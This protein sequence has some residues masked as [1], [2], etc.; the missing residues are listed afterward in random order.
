MKQILCFGLIVFMFAAFIFSAVGAE[1]FDS[2]NFYNADSDTAYSA[3]FY[4]KHTEIFRSGELMVDI[5]LK[6]ILSCSA[7][8]DF[9]YLF[10]ADNLNCQLCIYRYNPA[11]NI[12]DSYAV[13]VNPIYDK[14]CFA[15]D[16]SGNIYFA[17]AYNTNFLYVQNINDY[18]VNNYKIDSRIC[19][20]INAGNDKILII[21]DVSVYAYEN[22]VCEKRLS[23]SLTY[24]VRYESKD[25]IS[26]ADG[27]KYNLTGFDYID[28][29]TLHHT[30][31]Q[32]TQSV[33]TTPV[34]PEDESEESEIRYEEISE[35]TY[36]VP[37][38]TT[39][40]KIKRAFASSVVTEIAKA[41]GGVIESGKVGTGT[42][43]YFE[44]GEVITLVI[45]SDVT[46][47]GN[48]NSRDTKAILDTLV[49]KQSLREPFFTAADLDY[50]GEITTKDALIISGMY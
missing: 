31:P 44:N 42:R 29:T 49:G 43:V 34:K 50:N 37:F 4:H 26:D 35:N 14:L 36:A 46:G 45:F 13:N 19:Q 9:V 1:N 20:I 25:I 6:N 2:F 41:D 33:N 32:N 3:H 28:E 23:S 16:K 17:G 24:P 47:E 38:G 39:V 10:A 5:E 12:M 8:A 18:S 7:S 40:S 11:E 27:N 15:S 22:G 30:E 21:T 48:I